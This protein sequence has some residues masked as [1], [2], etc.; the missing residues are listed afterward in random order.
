M[1]TPHEN[2]PELAKAL[3]V[4]TLYLKREDLN[5]YGSHKGRSIPF[6]IDHYSAA[7]DRKFAISSSGNAALAAVIHIQEINKNASEPVEL[8]VYVGHRIAPHKLEKLE[9]YAGE[10]I[11]ILIKEHP[12]HALTQATQEGFRSLRQSV[13]DVALTGYTSLAEELV[14]IKDLGT[15]FIGTSSGTT[16][17]ALAQYVLKNK[18]SVQIHLIQTSSCHPFID[19]FESSDAPDELSIADAIV[20]HNAYRSAALIPLIQKTGGRGWTASN[21]TIRAAQELTEK[22]A[23]LN[24]STNSALSIVGAMKAVGIGY[25]IKGAV[26][27]MI[28]GD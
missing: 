2:H 26:V 24:I 21:D 10:H 12:L 28:C 16:A 18:P 9:A 11:R 23:Q 6:M 15:I 27:C 1:L 20:D 3:G 5:P 4:S 25:E 14:S 7:G 22:Y 8:E 13:D 19:A 17:Q